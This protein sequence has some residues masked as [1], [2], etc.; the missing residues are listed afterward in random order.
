MVW[1]RVTDGVGSREKRWKG[2][3]EISIVYRP[4]LDVNG[5]KMY[6]ELVQS[7][8]LSHQDVCFWGIQV[9]QTAFAGS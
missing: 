4:A 9:S 2:G 7:I 8:E 3:Q 6:D 1:T 5:V